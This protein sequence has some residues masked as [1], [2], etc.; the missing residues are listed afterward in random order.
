MGQLT[1]KPFFPFPCFPF[2]SQC[3]LLPFSRQIVYTNIEGRRTH[4][5]VPTILTETVVCRHGPGSG[6]VRRNLAS[7]LQILISL[8]RQSFELLTYI[9]FATFQVFYLFVAFWQQFVCVPLPPNCRHRSC[10]QQVGTYVPFFPQSGFG[11]SYPAV[12]YLVSFEVCVFPRAF[13]N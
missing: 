3:C 4:N 13:C 1:Q 9:L 12:L 8:G 10:L 6:P 2:P 11:F 7:T 5:N